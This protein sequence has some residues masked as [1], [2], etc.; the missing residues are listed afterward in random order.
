MHIPI[1]LLATAYSEAEFG[2][3]IMRQQGGNG[4]GE[5]LSWVPVGVS[6]L[7]VAHLFA[8]AYWVYRLAL[9]TPEERRKVQ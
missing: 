4:E 2:H 3:G 1:P 6:A 8:L 7:V 5:G 9:D